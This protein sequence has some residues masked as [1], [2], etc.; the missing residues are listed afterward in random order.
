MESDRILQRAEDALRRH[1]AVPR[2]AQRARQRQREGFFRK[3]GRVALVTGLFVI[4]LPL[5]GLIVGPVGTSGLMIA[6]LAFIVA[7]AALTVVAAAP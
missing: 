1:G 4:G 2:L 6:V 3:V 5:W 7:A